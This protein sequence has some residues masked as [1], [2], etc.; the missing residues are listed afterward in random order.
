MYN[1]RSSEPSTCAMD[2]MNRFGI[3]DVV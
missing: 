1:R 2:M 3:G